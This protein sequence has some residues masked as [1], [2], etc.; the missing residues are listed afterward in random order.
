[1]KTLTKIQMLKNAIDG[2][3]VV[4]QARCV[5][6]L[7]RLAQKAA[8]L[9]GVDG[10]C[11][12]GIYNWHWGNGWLGNRDNQFIHAYNLPAGQFCEYADLYRI[13][14]TLPANIKQLTL[15]RTSADKF[16]KKILPNLIEDAIRAKK[17][18]EKFATK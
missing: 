5:I 17:G 11:S 14:Y 7:S 8:D 1:M 9:A 4:Q 2:S 15:I 12:L 3:I 6:S 13:D 10:E 18:A 16:A